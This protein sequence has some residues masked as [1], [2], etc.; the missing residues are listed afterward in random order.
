MAKLYMIHG[1]LGAGKTTFAKQLEQAIPGIRFTHDEWMQRLYGVDPHAQDFP[2]YYERV[3]QL[4]FSLWPRC[5]QLKLN[6]IL[7][8]NF[9]TRKQR[10]ETRNI[11]A[12]LGVEVCLYELKCSPET[13]W[14]RIEKRNQQLEHNL[15]ISKNTFDLLQSQFEPLA[16]DEEHIKQLL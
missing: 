12:Q 2:I 5:L 13:A 15:Y 7:D 8:L 1:F 14:A 3:S 9:W 10:D 4:I 16:E 6:V 11:A